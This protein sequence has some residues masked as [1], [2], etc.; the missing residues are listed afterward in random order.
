MCIK[1]CNTLILRTS[2]ALNSKRGQQIYRIFMVQI[3]K[4][5]W[6]NQKLPHPNWVASSFL[7]DCHCLIRTKSMCLWNEKTKK[8]RLHK[9]NWE[10]I[11]VIFKIMRL[12]FWVI[13]LHRASSKFAMDKLREIKVVFKI[14]SFEF[15]KEEFQIIWNIQRLLY[16]KLRNG[17]KKCTDAENCMQSF[18]LAL[19]H[20]LR[21]ACEFP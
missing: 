9:R 5:K 18:S 8:K 2:S 14:Y 3:L 20:K 11:H 19:W 16:F 17:V 12:F 15:N 13:G 7:A 1:N 21:F 4:K 6:P 10:P